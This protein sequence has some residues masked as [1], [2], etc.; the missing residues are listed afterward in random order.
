MLLTDNSSIF[1]VV[2]EYIV[3]YS[4]V[5]YPN[6]LMAVTHEWP[7]LSTKLLDPFFNF[8]LFSVVASSLHLGADMSL[9]ADTQLEHKCWP[10]SSLFSVV[11]SSLHLGTDMSLDGG[12]HLTWALVLTDTSLDGGMLLPAHYRQHV[13]GMERGALS[14]C[15]LPVVWTVDR[16]ISGW[17]HAVHLHIPWVPM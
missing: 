1:F 13:S 6:C 12:M 10:I 2:H 11:A 7:V 16:H 3:F 15:K 14:T 5:Q 17:R 8:S 9:E 4:A